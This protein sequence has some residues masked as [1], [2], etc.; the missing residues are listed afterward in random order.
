MSRQKRT[1]CRRALILSEAKDPSKPTEVALYL[2]L[3]HLF[4]ALFGGQTEEVDFIAEFQQQTRG[5]DCNDGDDDDDDRPRLKR[6][7]L[8]A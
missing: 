2:F 6:F 8:D 4:I 7:G 1:A 3:F 5:D